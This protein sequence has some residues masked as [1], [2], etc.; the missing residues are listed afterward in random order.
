MTEKRA[1]NTRE[2]N[3]P[4]T[5]VGRLVLIVLVTE[6]STT[7]GEARRI[8]THEFFCL[9]HPT[10]FSARYQN[11]LPVAIRIGLKVFYMSLNHHGAQLPVSYY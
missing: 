8:R 9:M 2:C 1:P 5:D 6:L 7:R 3:P 4:V 10:V 11:V